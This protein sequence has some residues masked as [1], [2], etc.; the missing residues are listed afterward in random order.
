M[1]IAK[2]F[3]DFVNKISEAE[4]KVL[5]TPTGQ[6]MTERLLRMKLEENPN[7]TPEEWS[8]TKSEF[9]TFIFA[10][11]VQNTP[12]AMQELSQ[13]VWDALQSQ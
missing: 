5:N 2:N 13:H 1:M 9:M 12:E 7:L 3:D 4:R 6:E 10:M 8:Q 11:F